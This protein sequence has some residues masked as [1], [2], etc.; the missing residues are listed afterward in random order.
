MNFSGLTTHQKIMALAA[1]FW[2]LFVAFSAG[3]NF[4]R[5]RRQFLEDLKNS[6]KEFWL[7]TFLFPFRRY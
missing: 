5:N 7:A 6:P 4:I 2:L 1:I 3:I